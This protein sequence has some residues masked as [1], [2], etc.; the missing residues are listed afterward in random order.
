MESAQISGKV[1]R[2]LSTMHPSLSKPERKRYAEFDP[3]RWYPWTADIA[4]EFTDLM[5]RSPRDT[6]FA[7]GLAYAA[8]KGLPEDSRLTATEVVAGLSTL[9]SAFVDS[10]GSG[11]DVNMQRPGFA[12]VYYRGMPGFANVCIAIIGELTQ[13]LQAVGAR[14]LDVKH[15]EGCRLQGSDACKFE[16]RWTADPGDA[17]APAA[18]AVE[19][20]VERP[21]SALYETTSERSYERSAAAPEPSPNPWPSISPRPS[22]PAAAPVA[23]AAPVTSNAASGSAEDLFEQLRGRLADAERQSARYAELEAHITALEAHSAELE[24]ALAAARSDADSARHALADLK[25][26][27]R[28]LVQ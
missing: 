20:P 6:S 28:D 25:R 14:G 15:A 7:R 27:L 26:R 3:D 18:T 9:P 8:T 10:A 21:S 1:F 23:A 11:F 2:F 22:A 12:E 4:G 13:R 24:G 5:R 16:V 17:R 19:R